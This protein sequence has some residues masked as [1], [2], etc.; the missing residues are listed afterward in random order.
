M[1]AISS[2]VLPSAVHRITSTSRLVNG[3]SSSQGLSPR[4]GD[5]T[6]WAVLASH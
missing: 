1:I 6:R 3:A 2:L 4:R 5:S